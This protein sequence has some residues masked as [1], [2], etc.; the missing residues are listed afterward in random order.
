MKPSKLTDFV[1]E[2]YFNEKGRFFDVFYKVL[3]NKK[4][5]LAHS[6]YVLVRVVI[7]AS[8]L[9]TIHNLCQFYDVPIYNSYRELV[10]RPLFVIYGF[11]IGS[12]FYFSY[13][14]WRKEYKLSTGSFQDDALA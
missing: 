3:K 6:G 5:F 10:I 12:F 7:F 2:L 8:F 14:V 9:A 11:F 13:S 1:S 4:T